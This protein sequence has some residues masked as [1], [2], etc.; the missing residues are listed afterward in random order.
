MCLEGEELLQQLSIEE[1]EKDFLPLGPHCCIWLTS[2]SKKIVLK[3][4]IGVAFFEKMCI[5]QKYEYRTFLQYLDISI[6]Y[7]THFCWPS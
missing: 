3:M 6:F 5:I 2:A 4:K 1:L 7:E